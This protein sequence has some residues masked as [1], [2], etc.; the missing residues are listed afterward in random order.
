MPGS[1]PGGEEGEDGEG[2]AAIFGEGDLEGVKMGIA[3]EESEGECQAERAGMEE[4]AEA[5]DASDC[6]DEAKGVE[7][8]QRG[9][10][11][12]K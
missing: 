6:K 9:E 4:G 7:G 11:S 3:E 8:F 1:Q 10:A 2:E 12:A 5:E